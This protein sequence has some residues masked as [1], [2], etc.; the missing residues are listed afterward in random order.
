MAM[1]ID[2]RFGPQADIHENYS[3]TPSERSALAVSRLTTS[4]NFVGCT[5]GS[6]PGFAPLSSDQ[7]VAR[8]NQ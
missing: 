4:S 7:N 2:V 6:S 1:L 5:T 3:I 8:E